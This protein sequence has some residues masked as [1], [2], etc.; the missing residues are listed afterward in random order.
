MKNFISIL[1]ILIAT[2]SVSAQNKGLTAKKGEKINVK[3]IVITEK[4]YQDLTNPTLN[5]RKL[6]KIA[7]RNSGKPKVA[8]NPL[9]RRLFELQRLRNPNTGKLPANIKELEKAY[10]LSS[11]SGLQSR[12][13]AGGLNFTQSGPRNVGGRTR[14]LAID[15]SDATGNTILAGGTTGGMWKSTDK[16]QTWTRTTALSEHPSVTAIAQD[17]REGHTST[18]YYTTGEYIGSADAKGAFYAG[19]GVF[20]STDNGDSWTKLNAT[21]SNTF[22]SFDNLFDICWNICVDPNNGDIYVATYGGIYVSNDEGNSWSLEIQTVDASLDSNERSYSSITDIICTPAG[23]KYATLSQGGNQ[24]EGIWRKGSATD[25]NW[26]E[27]T[28]TNFPSS[29]RRIVLANAPSNTSQDI[30]YLLAQTTGSGLQGHSFWKLS[31]T[32]ASDYTWVDRSQNLP[33]GGDGDRD[34]N[35]YDSQGS[36][37]MIIKV[38]PDDENMVFI[39][40]T[41]LYRSDDA[42]A[43]AATPLSD[44]V[45]NESNTYWIGGYATEN[46]VSQYD[47]HHPDVHSLAFID[48]ST[49]VCGHDGGLSITSNFKQTKDSGIGE[50]NKPVDWIFLN[51]SYLTTQAYT[52]A[53]DQ[54]KTDNEY[55]ISGFQDNGSWLATSSSADSDWN[56]Y[57]S[58]DGSYCSILDQGEHRLSSSQNGTVYLENNKSYDDVEYFYTR[59]DPD[60]AEGQLFINPFITDANNSEI[61]YYASGQYV[62]RNTNIFDIP[63]FQTSSATVNWEKLEISK[64]SGTVSALE[65][66]VYPAHILYYGTS[67]GK[68]YKIENSHSKNAV[69]TDITSSNMPQ[70]VSGTTSPYISSIDAN[71]LNANEVIVSFSNY[72]IESIFYTKDGGTTWEAISGNLEDG[73]DTGNGPSVRSVS[74]MVSPNDTTYYAGTS[75][76]LYSTSILNGSA[77]TWTHE[78]ADKIGTTVVDMIKSRRDGFIAVA[79]HGN[80]IF[81]ANADYSSVAPVALI[82]LTQ[83][84]LIA[85]DKMDFMNRSIGDGITD[86]EW[87][88]EGAEPATSTE[89]FPTEI[90]YNTPGTYKVSLKVTN[91]NGDNTQIIDAAVVVKSIEADFTASATEVDID[92]EIT[93]T[94]KSTGTPTT[95]SWNFPGGTPETSTE[96]NPVVTY[97]S[98]GTYDVSLTIGDDTYSDTKTKTGYI[99]VIDKDNFDDNLLYNISE[100]NQDN[101]VQ[102]TFGGDNEGPV[103]GHTNLGIDQYAEKFTITNPNLNSVKQVH[104]FP[105]IMQSNSGDPSVTIKIWNG[106]TEPSEEV[107]SQVVPYSELTELEFNIIDL[108][109]S[110]AV[111]KDFFVGYELN[112]TTPVDTFAVAHLP[113]EADE[114]RSNTAYMHYD[115]KWYGYN[116]IFEDNPTVS[117]AIK[118]L[119]GYDAGATAIDDNLLDTKVEKLLIYPNPMVYKTNVKFPNQNNQKYRLVVVDASGKVVRIIENITNDNVII[120][121]EQLKPGIHI[122]NLSGEKIY[123]GKLLV[124]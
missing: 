55:M 67:T 70:V 51:N 115:N 87:T 105:S 64:V 42:F 6:S 97:S 22:S 79:T 16:G 12:T 54:D 37:N 23:V 112:Y 91:A 47:N 36:Y 43:T 10:V 114:T 119:V 57:G 94:D 101:L 107:Y 95:W 104:I 106:T 109:F 58:G 102:A 88:F 7:D 13:K 83:D 9:A 65:S 113:L 27:I 2:C 17:P 11:R 84:T 78:A 18:W 56:Y 3:N 73:S 21:T 45:D 117:L 92:T 50:D 121:R 81:T 28:P 5:K 110:V 24:N 31:Y 49:L 1:A 44:G 77:T 82:G 96:E 40:G 61:M 14:A 26:E 90:S 80:G 52:V 76:G 100:E 99:T 111:D 68:I 63:K 59:V 71:P 93:F 41:N 120:N 72:G 32:S 8:D 98:V 19:N 39:G 34:V 86:Y 74:I 62:W 69:V 29:Y 116:E 60:G 118:A 66:S 46:N 33:V 35:G 89:E 30:V 108:D 38:A 123:K 4:T 124:K 48:N 103:T 53:I 25:A 85:G 75:T 122:I 15:I 20:K